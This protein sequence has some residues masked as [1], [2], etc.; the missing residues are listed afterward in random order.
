MPATLRYFA[1]A[2]NRLERCYPEPVPDKP[3]WCGHLAD[4]SRQLR[5]LPDRWVD[6]RILQDLLRI[7]PRR[8]QQILAPCIARQIGASGVADREEV[9]THLNR[10]TTGEATHYEHRRR[11][12]LAERIEV[13]QEERRNA[14]LVEAPAAIVNQEME[15]LPTGVAITRGQITVSFTTSQE[16]LEKLLALAMAISNDPLL[17]ERMATGAK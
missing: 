14:V 1:G 2:Q 4:I 15:D 5:G 8:A 9:I 12:R 11:R 6:C 17:F 13:F 3:T 16:A 7:G 10:L